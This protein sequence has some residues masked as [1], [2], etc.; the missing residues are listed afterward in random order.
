[1]VRIMADNDVQGQ[2]NDL[3]RLLTSDL[4]ADIFT[5]LAVRV[6]T[7]ESL[8]LTRDASDEEV[9][10][11]CQEQGVVLF[12]GNRNSEGPGSLEA[13]IRAANQVGSLPVITLGDPQRLT[14]ERTYAERAA[15]RLLEYLL[16][17]DAYR[18]AGRLYVP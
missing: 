13:T 18:G 5:G 1:M 12:T 4:W 7:F 9:W 15:E 17:I 10:R 11:A 14:R 2:F 6:E 16:D 8:G 3:L